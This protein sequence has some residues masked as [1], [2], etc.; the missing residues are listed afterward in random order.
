[1]EAGRKWAVI[2]CLLLALFCVLIGTSKADDFKV[3]ALEEL[4]IDFRQYMP[5]GYYP[6]ITNNGLE[7]REVGQ[8]LDVIMNLTVMK[9]F[10]W[11]NKIVS[12]TDRGRNDSG[13]GQFRLVGW[14]FRFGLQLSSFVQFGYYHFSQH[15][16]DG[17][18]PWHYPVEDAYELRF[19]IFRAPAPRQGIIP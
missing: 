3:I 13:P 7:N 17:Q 9:Y 12:L 18:F 14:N 1:M 5:N 11:D 6:Y 4:A 2:G 19:I 10:Y 15:L 16:L 8:G